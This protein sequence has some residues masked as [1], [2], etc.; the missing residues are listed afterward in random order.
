VRGTN[1]GR[2]QY[3]G[4]RTSWYRVNYGGG[5]NSN[6]AG[7]CVLQKKIQNQGHH[8][9]GPKG[10][11]GGA[12]ESGGCL[13]DVQGEKIRFMELTFERY[14]SLTLGGQTA[15]LKQEEGT[16]EGRVIGGGWCMLGQFKTWKRG[17]PVCTRL[18]QIN[19]H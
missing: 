11:Q 18:Y 10:G 3:R 15:D 14:S 19:R 2:E 8:N 1:G 17:T 6:C 5:E 16:I 4:N 12:S 9:V 7:R 13:L